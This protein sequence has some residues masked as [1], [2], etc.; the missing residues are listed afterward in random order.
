MTVT[1]D[2]RLSTAA[3]GLSSK[4]GADDALASD[5][6]DARR[7]LAFGCPRAKPL[8]DRQSEHPLSI[9]E[10]CESPPPTARWTAVSGS[11]PVVTKKLV[12][13]D[14]GRAWSVRRILASEDQDKALGR[15]PVQGA[16][17]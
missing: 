16:A 15:A 2:V 13:E 9:A 17:G 12:A 4:G 6:G 5:G 14:L 11:T 3:A 10:L 7:W 1:C 8:D